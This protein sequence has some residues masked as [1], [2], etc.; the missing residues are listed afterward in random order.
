MRLAALAMVAGLTARASAQV[1]IETG[2]AYE[3]RRVAPPEAPLRGPRFALVTIE[4]FACFPCPPSVEIQ[5]ALRGALS[6][7]GDRVRLLF[8]NFPQAQFAG[9]EVAA[10][11]AHEAEAEGRFWPYHDALF[12]RAGKIDRDDLVRAAVEVG[13]DAARLERALM[14]GRHREAVR[15]EEGRAR[16]RSIR[17][18]PT[19]LVNGTVLAGA[20]AA[21]DLEPAIAEAMGRARDALARGVPL[22]R[23]FE[24]L[25]GGHGRQVLREQ[26]VLGRAPVRGPSRA[27]VTLVLFGD[28]ADPQTGAALARIEGLRAAHPDDVRLAFRHG[29]GTQIVSDAVA[30]AAVEAQAQGRFWDLAERLRI[31]PV[32]RPGLERAARLAGLDPVALRAAL[33]DG[34][35]QAAVEADRAEALRLAVEHGALFVNGRRV[36][37]LCD[38]DE[39]RALIDEE[40]RGGFLGNL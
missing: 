11:A 9:A 8:H 24:A 14:D 21:R 6:R 31:P 17:E 40:R 39:L 19:L 23:L 27:R 20:G 37:P 22:E 15:V 26:V 5:P 29:A 3:L 13:M 30:Q 25:V 7:Y 36:S 33:A 12:A 34:R 18:S 28:L 38:E 4:E 2:R 10:E 32:D 16:G 1:A 35:H